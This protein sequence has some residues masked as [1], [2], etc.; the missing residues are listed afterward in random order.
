MKE[1]K[2]WSIGMEPG[3]IIIIDEWKADRSDETKGHGEYFQEFRVIQKY[4]D[5]SGKWL[6]YVQQKSETWN[7]RGEWQDYRGLIED[8]WGKSSAQ[9]AVEAVLF[10]RIEMLAKQKGNE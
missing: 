1:W 7:T 3:D 6:S 5:S 8:G 9:R 4:D 10:E 2:E